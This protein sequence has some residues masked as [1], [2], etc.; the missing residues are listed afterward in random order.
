[1]LFLSWFFLKYFFSIPSMLHNLPLS[2]F[3]IRKPF[4]GESINHN[5]ICNQIFKFVKCS[6]IY[7]IIVISVVSNINFVFEI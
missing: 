5:R 3:N 2:G 7:V 6:N 4:L 1:M